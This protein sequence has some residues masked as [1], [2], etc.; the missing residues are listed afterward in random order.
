MPAVH[1]RLPGAAKIFFEEF[2]MSDAE[3]AQAIESWKNNSIVFRAF[4]FDVA[5]GYFAN[6][7]HI[8]ILGAFSLGRI[9]TRVQEELFGAADE[10]ETV[11]RVGRRRIVS[12]GRD[13]A[14]FFVDAIFPMQFVAKRKGVAKK[15]K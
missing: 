13:R 3:F 15:I 4:L 11:M 2:F 5:F 6:F 8:N 9:E 12:A 10:N 7:F 14:R 1:V